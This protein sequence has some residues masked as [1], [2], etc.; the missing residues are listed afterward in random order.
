MF[1]GQIGPAQGAGVQ[2]TPSGAVDTIAGGVRVLFDGVAAPMIYASAG[3]VSCVAPYAL[4]GKTTTQIQVEYNGQ[5]SNA[6]TV[7]VQVASPAIFTA[8]A[9][10]K[11]QGAILNQDNSVNS[12]STPAAAGSIV[13]IYATGAGQTNPDGMDGKVTGA[14]PPAPRLPVTVSIGG[15]NADI[16][17][18]GAAPGLVSGVLQINARV[19]SGLVP[20]TPASVK[21]TVGAASTLNTVTVSVK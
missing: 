18:A 1:G 11:G 16:L 19:P 3:Q 9:S 10:G 14:P 5:K 13:V 6:V 20:N 15:T 4:A 7:P 17:Y 12:S 21:I 8:D 2:L